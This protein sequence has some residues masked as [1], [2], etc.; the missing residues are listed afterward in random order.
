MARDNVF[1]IARWAINENLFRMLVTIIHVSD[2]LPM[3]TYS[4]VVNDFDNHGSLAGIG[5]ALKEHDS[6]DFDLRPAGC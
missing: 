1:L 6:S 5:T 2:R 4:S 3:P